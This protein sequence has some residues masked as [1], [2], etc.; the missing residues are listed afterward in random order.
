MSRLLFVLSGTRGDVEPVLALAATVAARGAR[1]EA[2]AHAAHEPFVR[3]AGLPFHAL[4]DNPSD[5]MR[6]N[7][8]LSGRASA[9]S[10]TLR[11]VRAA[12]PLYAAMASAV[13]PLLAGVDG[14]VLGLP[15]IWLLPIVAAAGAR[16]ACAFLQ[17]LS[18]TSLAA[19]AL[20]P[21]SPPG[22]TGR[23]LSH[24][25]AEQLVWRPWRSTLAGWCRAHG[26]PRPPAAGPFPALYRSAVPVLYGFSSLVFPRP[27]D[28]P[29]THVVT[30]YWHQPPTPWTP[31]PA[32]ARFL[33][34]H[35]RPVYV[36][37]GSAAPLYRELA[38][39][40][41][42]ELAAREIP[43]ILQGQKEEGATGP[44]LRIRGSLPHDWLFPRVAVAV[45]H[46]GAGTFAAALR[47]GA[48]SVIVPSGADAYFWQRRCVELGAGPAAPAL[49]HATPAGVAAAVQAC[50][51]EPRYA[52]RAGEL[53]RGLATEQGT[54][55]A[56]QILAALRQPDAAR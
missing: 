48:P 46:G 3:D 15:T 27:H 35:P 10:D 6:G 13:L 29:P 45:H 53:A 21:W 55:T 23:R 36:G 17:P 11:Y 25:L 31:Q 4:P 1:V 47:A 50:L 26:L 42:R 30:G 41:A 34:T 12:R 49:R 28:W 24:L 16:P 54:D 33:A 18:R 52:E 32:L 20:L 56:A 40:L 9:L 51:R 44:V 19:S 2:A 37:F 7:A 14:V 22:A 39:A 8:A 38:A 5:L 43:A